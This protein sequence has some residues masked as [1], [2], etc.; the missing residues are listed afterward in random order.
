MFGKLKGIIGDGELVERNFGLMNR[1]NMNKSKFD[2]LHDLLESNDDRI[3]KSEGHIVENDE[4]RG[5]T[6]QIERYNDRR[7]HVKL[8]RAGALGIVPRLV[9]QIVNK[10]KRAM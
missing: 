9:R 1:S 4:D 6:V 10:A 8:V 3:V 2:L 7:S 5:S